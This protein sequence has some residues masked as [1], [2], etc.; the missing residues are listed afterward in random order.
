MEIHE[1]NTFSGTLGSGNFFATD[2]GTDTSKVSAESMFAPLNERID[3]II[4]GGTAPS[5]AEVTDAR[6]GASVLGGTQYASLGDAVRGQAT[7]L[8]DLNSKV[9]ND[10]ADFNVIDILSFCNKPN[11]TYSGVS[12]TWNGDV[13]AVSGTASAGTGIN[14]FA[15]TNTL[16][17]FFKSGKTYNIKYSSQNV[18]FQIY[19]YSGGNASQLLS[20]KQDVSWT[21]PSNITGVIL[22]LRVEAGVTV[23]ETVEPHILN[24]FQSEIAQYADMFA[25]NISANYPT[26]NQDLNNYTG[27]KT[28]ILDC[29]NVANAPLSAGICILE[30]SGSDTICVQSCIFTTGL[31]Y[32]RYINKN[33]GTY[34]AW[35]IVKGVGTLERNS[36]I[37][38]G[39]LNNFVDTGYRFVSAPNTIENLPIA[40][41]GFL[42]VYAF[43]TTGIIYQEYVSF[44]SLT[45][46]HRKLFGGVWSAWAKGAGSGDGIVNNYT[47]TTT[48]SITTDT[49][50][51]LNAVDDESTSE[52]DATDMTG[53]IMSMLTDTGYCKLSPGTFYVSGNIDMPAGSMIEGCGEKTILRLLSSID[54]GYIIKAINKCTIKDLTLS[55]GKNAPTFGETSVRDGIHFTKIDD[56]S[57]V[58]ESCVFD[59]LFITNFSGSGIFCNKTG[60]GVKENILATN[61]AITACKYGLNIAY[62]SEYHKFTNVLIYGCD[63]ACINNGGNNIFASCTFNGNTGFVIDNSSGTLDNPG[64][65]SCIGCTFNHIGGNTGV[66]VSITNNYVTFNFVG[67]QFWYGEI[68]VVN[69]K[70]IVFDGCSFGG[71][72]P[73]PIVLTNN[74]AVI[75]TNNVFYRTP[76]INHSGNISLVFVNCYVSDN[77]SPVTI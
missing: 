6:L 55:G 1:L 9:K 14:L 10:L 51:W 48:P 23:N 12:F 77:G 16:P 25:G 74:T 44:N 59:G 19:D 67:C 3:N 4:A 15:S 31:I 45:H 35:S 52:S 13:C 70:G 61:I 46:Y 30:C 8:F 50:N 38:S 26:P 28:Y 49:N 36:L 39:N 75:F 37:D 56:D 72:N 71:I 7:A 32:T 62:K 73:A 5:A 24:T 21:V 20:T 76:T 42:W 69:S 54:T 40:G 33:N 63:T 11:A 22:R 47:I 41:A 64:H 66:G 58:V 29:A 53:A 34:S 43:T 18:F 68:D 17:E 57:S 2:N 65:G 60:G 27:N